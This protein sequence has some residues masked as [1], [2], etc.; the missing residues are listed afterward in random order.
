MKIIVDTREKNSLVFSELVSNKAE[1][2]LKQLEIADY[3]IGDI[4]IERKTVNDFI[5]SIINKRLLRQLQDLQQCSSRAIII[6]GIEEQELYDDKQELGMHA[7]AVR[8][9][10]LSIIL[11]FSTPIIFTKDYMDT[12]KFLLVLARRFEKNKQEASLNFKRKARS[13]SEQQQFILEG[14]PGIGP[15]TAKE[16][17]KKFRTIKGVVNAQ[18]NDI[19]KTNKM[20]A[21]KA[22]IFSQIINKRYKT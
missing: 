6:E 9:M 16:L 14:F 8:G 19:E 21:K 1:L 3:I 5:S 13:V 15:V 10:I 20:N 17:L 18:I 4:A 2:E 12:A 7:N 11:D 22:K